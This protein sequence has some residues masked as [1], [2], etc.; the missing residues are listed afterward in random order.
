MTA[1]RV[2]EE[3]LI[4]CTTSHGDYRWKGNVMAALER[5]FSETVGDELTVRIGDRFVPLTR[6]WFIVA[7]RETVIAWQGCMPAFTPFVR[8]IAFE[9]VVSAFG[10]EESFNQLVRSMLDVNFYREWALGDPTPVDKGFRPAGSVLPK[11]TTGAD[12]GFP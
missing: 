11:A 5:K 4:P 12:E 8:M 3:W 1:T 10:G 6:E 2:N 9:D 7:R